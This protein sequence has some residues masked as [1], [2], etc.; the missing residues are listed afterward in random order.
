[1]A[2]LSLS[3]SSPLAFI[4]AYCQPLQYSKIINRVSLSSND[5]VLVLTAYMHEGL[6]LTDNFECHLLVGAPTGTGIVT[7][8]KK[9]SFHDNDTL[10]FQS[11]S[12][13]EKVWL[14]NDDQHKYKE[15]I[16]EPKDAEESNIF[17]KF[18]P[19]VKRSQHMAGFE[20]VFTSFKRKLSEELNNWFTDY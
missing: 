6:R 4:P 16:A 19:N 9:I 2:F 20:I 10:V 14:M 1:M 15:I 8:V 17:L 12:N 3:Q 11:G 18:K 5:T 13:D 7:T